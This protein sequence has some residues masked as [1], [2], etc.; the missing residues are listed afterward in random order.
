MNSTE[1]PPTES[2]PDK[3]IFIKSAN[4]RKG[5]K[6][7]SGSNWYG[8]LSTEKKEDH[9]KKLRIACQQKKLLNLIQR[10]SKNHTRIQIKVI[11]IK[12]YIVQNCLTTSLFSIYNMVGYSR[13]ITIQWQTFRSSMFCKL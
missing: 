11:N 13:L 4:G 3:G 1:C 10:A 7:V 6:Q 9:L 5:A 12:S 8:R 2:N